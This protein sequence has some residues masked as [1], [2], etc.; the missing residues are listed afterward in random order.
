MSRTMITV[1]RTFLNNETGE[2]TPYGTVM[3]DNE[4][5]LALLSKERRRDFNIVSE[6]K[7]KEL[8]SNIEYD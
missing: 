7:K 4:E 3:E 5:T 1:I 6:K 2:L 8:L